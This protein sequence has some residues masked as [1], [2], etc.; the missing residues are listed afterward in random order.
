MRILG[1][2]DEAVVSGSSA[3]VFAHYGLD[4]AGIARSAA[5]AFAAK[6]ARR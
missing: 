2:P 1:I 6:R 4:A 3:E 5:A